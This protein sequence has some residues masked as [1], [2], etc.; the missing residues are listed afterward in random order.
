MELDYSKQVYLHGHFYARGTLARI[1]F[2]GRVK[3]GYLWESDDYKRVVCIMTDSG[4]K[5]WAHDSLV[6]IRFDKY[7]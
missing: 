6:H 5:E 4:K 1:S 3:N 7:A 2:E